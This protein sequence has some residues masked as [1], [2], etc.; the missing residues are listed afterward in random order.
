[1]SRKD[2]KQQEPET[3]V[4]SEGH[5]RDRIIVNEN[6]KIPKEGLFVSL[7][8]YA[9]LIK[10]GVEVDIPRPVRKMID[11]RIE[12]ETVQDERGAFYNR[13]IPRITYTLI[14]ENVGEEPVTL[15]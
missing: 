8:G 5:I 1:M 2:E 9:Y 6:P 4:G 3:F 13:N 7:N 12:T 11:T 10:P 15:V 14:K